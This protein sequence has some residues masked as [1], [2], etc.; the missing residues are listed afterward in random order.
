MQHGC[1]YR[2]RHIHLEVLPRLIC[3]S[4]MK[5]IVIMGRKGE[6]IIRMKGGTG[7]ALAENI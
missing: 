2:M 5:K 7:W 4:D 3:E 1:V 6:A